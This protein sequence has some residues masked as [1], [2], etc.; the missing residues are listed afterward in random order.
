MLSNLVA[1]PKFYLR[2]PVEVLSS[3]YFPFRALISDYFLVLHHLWATC[4]TIAVGTSFI[5]W[6]L[7]HL[8]SYL[9][10]YEY[11]SSTFE[12]THS[13]SSCNIHLSTL[14]TRI[15]KCIHTKK[16]KEEKVK[17]IPIN[18]SRNQSQLNSYVSLY[19]FK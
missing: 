12:V 10:V 11:I 19:I 17:V 13:D 15:F 2:M 3:Y 1:Y 6:R 7:I 14:S 9:Y 4:I 5:L 18:Q 16:R 8:V